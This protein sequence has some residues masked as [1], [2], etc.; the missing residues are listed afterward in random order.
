M[1]LNLKLMRWRLLP[2]IELE[3]VAGTK[4][5]L[6]GAGTLGSNVARAL[7]GW[8][9]RH[10]TL[11]DNGRI[12]YSNPVRQ[13]LFEFEDSI[14]GKEKA[15][16]AAAALRRIFPGVEAAA[17]I[18]SIPM[19]GHAFPPD[20]RAKIAEDIATLEGLVQAHDVVFLLTDSRESRWLP[21]ALAKKHSKLCITAALGFDTFVVMRH[22]VGYEAH[23][24]GCYFCNDIVAPGDSTTDR[25]LDQVCLFFWF[26]FVL[27]LPR[28][29]WGIS[30]GL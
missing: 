4:A 18:L 24:L 15:P 8:G 20:H 17:H 5:L 9:V 11:V 22:G 3:K 2:A 13:S 1:D 27:V 12:S 28:S 29:T 14:A 16:A 19:P 21:T 25:T 10:I 7:M 6:L 30:L 26:W 23:D